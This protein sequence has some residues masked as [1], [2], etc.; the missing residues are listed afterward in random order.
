MFI[1]L[2]NEQ[3]L[4][5]VKNGYSFRLNGMTVNFENTLNGINVKITHEDTTYFYA[6]NN[7]LRHMNQSY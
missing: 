7:L 3:E 2:Y 6:G 1:A 4:S 5:A